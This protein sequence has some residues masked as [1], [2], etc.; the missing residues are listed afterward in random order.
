MKHKPFL[1]KTSD[2]FSFSKGL[3]K[4]IVKGGTKAGIEYIPSLLSSLNGLGLGLWAFVNDPVQVSTEFVKAAYNCIEFIQNN[5]PE[6]TL[7]LLV[8][9][10]KKLIENWDILVSIQE[11]VTGAPIA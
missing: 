3:T 4:G 2:L 11:S 8:P 1:S 7:K 9:E 5:T 10:L 6:K